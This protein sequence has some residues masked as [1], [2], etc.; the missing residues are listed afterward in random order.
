[1]KRITTLLV[2]AGLVLN[3]TSCNKQTS[4]GEKAQFIDSLIAEMTLEEKIGQLTL[5]TSG[6]SKTGPAMR[7]NYLEDIKAGK[8]G[9]VFNA[10][11]AH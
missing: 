7:D 4:T 10:R 2:L 9:N 5:Y 6:W 3:M 8:C 1:M 11:T